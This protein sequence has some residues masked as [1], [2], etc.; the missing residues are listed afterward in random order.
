M[1]RHHGV[2]SVTRIHAEEAEKVVDGELVGRVAKG[3]LLETREIEIAPE[4]TQL[5]AIHAKDGKAGYY[6]VNVEGDEVFEAFIPLDVE[7]RRNGG[8]GLF[9][10]YQNFRM[11]RE[12]GGGNERIRLYGT[13]DDKNGPDR[14]P[15]IFRS[16]PPGTPDFERLYGR[17]ADAESINRGIEDRLYWNRSHS[18]GYRGGLFDL[19]C[20]ARMTN[21]ITKGKHRI[22]L[23]RTL[24]A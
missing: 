13:D 15:E 24:S 10:M 9:R 17:R 23:E 2:Q 11:P 22:A 18:V 21:A 12:L 1:L 5:V 16:I 19:L 7:R 20:Y 8:S 14:R 6:K 4:V 3:G